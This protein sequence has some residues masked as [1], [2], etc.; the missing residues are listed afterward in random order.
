MHHLDRA[1]R[2]AERHPH[3]RTGS[4][5]GN[6]VICS[7]GEIA[8]VGQLVGQAGIERIIIARLEAAFDSG[9]RAAKSICL[10]IV[11]H[12]SHSSAP[13]RHS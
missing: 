1:A 7:G 6:Q 5:P 8:L 11:S 4:R 13:R 12:Y 10:V 3:Q 2:K 9:P